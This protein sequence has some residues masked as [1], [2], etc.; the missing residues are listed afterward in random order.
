V[1]VVFLDRDGVI[2]RYPGHFQYV[3]TLEEFSFL[4]G[5]VE[6]LK[7][8]FE[9]GFAIFVISNQAGIAK[10]IYSQTALDAITAH[11]RDELSRQGVE[12]AGVYYC[13]HLKDQDCVCRKPRTGLIES[14]LSQLPKKPSQ[15]ELA[16]MFFVGDSFTDV[17]TGKAASLRTILLF[18]GRETPESKDTWLVNPDFT[19]DDLSQAV[20]IILRS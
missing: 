6:A 18:S 9:S 1:R 2:N 16:K 3:T 20:D 11:M 5:S 12:L 14:A 19:A 15:Q 4:P 7:R 8:L 10:G 17:E 13:T